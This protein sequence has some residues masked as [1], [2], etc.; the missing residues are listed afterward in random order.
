[1]LFITC[2]YLN[3][4]FKTRVLFWGTM[5]EKDLV[6]YFMVRGRRYLGARM[7]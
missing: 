5:N 2:L 7:Y 6:S 1:M 4:P 3:H